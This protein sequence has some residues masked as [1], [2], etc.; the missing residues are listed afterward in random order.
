MEVTIRGKNT[1]GPTGL[2]CPITPN[3]KSE[4]LKSRVIFFG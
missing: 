1:K 4:E 2:L 3:N